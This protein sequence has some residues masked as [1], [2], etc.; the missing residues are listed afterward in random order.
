MDCEEL[1]V[2]EAAAY[3]AATSSPTKQQTAATTGR[4]TAPSLGNVSEGQGMSAGVARIAAGVLMLTL[5][6]ISA[7]R[8]QR[9]SLP[10][11][12]TRAAR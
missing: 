7:Q 3:G 2:T 4:G 6:A 10:D 9:S 12:N 1:A 5:R 11:M 8:A